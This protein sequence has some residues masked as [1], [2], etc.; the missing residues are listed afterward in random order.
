MKTES[1]HLGFITPC[2]CAGATPAEAEIRAP[3]IRG[4]LRWW[5]R[6]LGGTP[7]QEDAVFGGVSGEAGVG[8]ALIVRVSDVEVQRQWQPVNFSPGSNTGY[9]LYFAKAS[10]NG[11][12][13]NPKGALPVGASFAMHLIWRRPLAGKAQEIFNLALE[14]FLLLGSLGLRSTRGL[15]CFH[16]E[17]RPFSVEAFKSLVQAVNAKP[18]KFIAELA[19]FTGGPNDLL[20]ALGRQLRGLR[21]GYSAGTPHK[22][23]P[24]PLGSSQPRQASAVHLRPVKIAPGKFQIVVFEAPA[25]RVLDVRSRNGAPRLGGGVPAASDG[26]QGRRGGSGG[27]RR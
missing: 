6:V 23:N 17:E 12:R 13:W 7:E 14:S 9:L 2:F 21:Q 19:D 26:P 18:P 4:K 10:Q 1:F 8:S 22:S 15:G 3:S 20:E 16:A 27:Y 11:A 25:N 5:F 24:T